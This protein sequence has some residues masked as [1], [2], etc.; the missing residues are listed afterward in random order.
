MFDF[1]TDLEIYL[2]EMFDEEK[3]NVEEF[4]QETLFEDCPIYPS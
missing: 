4:K 3:K 1:A 2:K